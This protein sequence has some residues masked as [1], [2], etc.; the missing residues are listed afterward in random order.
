MVN[1]IDL[2]I[3]FSFSSSFSTS[4]SSINGRF[5]R[6]FIEEESRLSIYFSSE[7]SVTWYRK[8]LVTLKPKVPT[9]AVC[10]KHLELRK[11]ILTLLNLQKQGKTV[12]VRRA[13]FETET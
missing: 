9:K 8:P 10:A 7:F 3:S 12:E 5:H 1:N 11:E 2:I 4:Q 6:R 13:H